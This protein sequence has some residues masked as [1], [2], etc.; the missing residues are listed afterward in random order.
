MSLRFPPRIACFVCGAHGPADYPLFISPH[1]TT[2]DGCRLLPHFPFLGELVPPLGLTPPSPDTSA[3]SCRA[4]YNNLLK[5]WD[6]NEKGGVPLESRY[7]EIL[8]SFTSYH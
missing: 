4:C 7:V 1:G 8:R 2:A 6:A 3:S 5:Q